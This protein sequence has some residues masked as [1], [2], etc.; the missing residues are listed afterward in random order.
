MSVGEGIGMY[1]STFA[2]TTVENRHH[3]CNGKIKVCGRFSE[4]DLNVIL[5]F[6]PLC[7]DPGTAVPRVQTVHPR[8]NPHALLAPDA[9]R[10]ILHH[11]NILAAISSHAAC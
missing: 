1:Y 4:V 6:G 2:L 10:L 5:C 8:G 11:T 7:V 9:G 3:E